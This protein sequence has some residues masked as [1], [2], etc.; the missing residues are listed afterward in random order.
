MP[1]KA[2]PGC[3]GDSQTRPYYLDESGA[4]S[5]AWRLRATGAPGKDTLQSVELPVQCAPGLS[6]FVSCHHAGVGSVDAATFE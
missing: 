4:N 5:A 1:E 6:A 3:I 2:E